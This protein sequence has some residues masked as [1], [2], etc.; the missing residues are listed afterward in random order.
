MTDLVVSK[1][2]GPLSQNI[3]QLLLPHASGALG[4]EVLNDHHG[5]GANGLYVLEALLPLLEVLD[6]NG[7][8]SL[9]VARYVW[10]VGIGIP[11]S[12]NTN[13][14]LTHNAISRN[15]IDAP[16]VPDSLQD[17]LLNCFI[18]LNPLRVALSLFGT[19]LTVST[20]GV[21]SS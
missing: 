6:N 12:L 5:H 4:L 21:V 11:K 14:K 3:Q 15:S 1:G 2:R 10:M 16:V 18:F 8:S 7:A 13:T 9:F 20:L 17:L 19:L